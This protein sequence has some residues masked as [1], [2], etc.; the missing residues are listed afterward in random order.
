MLSDGLKNKKT[1]YVK[2]YNQAATTAKTLKIAIGNLK[3]LIGYQKQ[4]YMVDD[5]SGA[6]TK[7]DDVLT[8]LN[9]DYNTI[10]NTVLPGTKRIIDNLDEQIVDALANEAMNEQVM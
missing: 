10:I 6:G 4:A 8:R 9:N 3:N 5:V 1:N 7:L 2:A